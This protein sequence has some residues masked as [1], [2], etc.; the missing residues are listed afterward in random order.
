MEKLRSWSD[1][2]GDVESVFPRDDLL[3]W[4]TLYWLTGAI[5]TSFT[6]YAL[7][8]QPRTGRVDVPAAVSV[9]PKEPLIGP[10]ALVRHALRRIRAARTAA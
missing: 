10:R 2:H 7:R 8:R 5:G 1:C 6:P 3:T 4:V 9:S